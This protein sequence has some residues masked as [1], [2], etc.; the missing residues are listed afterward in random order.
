MSDGLYAGLYLCGVA[1]LVDLVRR[2]T[3]GQ[4][5]VGA[6]SALAYL[7]RPEG[8]GLAIVAALLL[9]GRGFLDR[10]QRRAALLATLALAIAAAALMA[11]LLDALG[12]A[13]ALHAH[14]EEE[15]D[16]ARRR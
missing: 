11:P 12:D 8:V 1:V 7:V 5:A 4:A 2:P 9:V 10:E 6:L 15:R 16:G 13:R 14:P 3:I